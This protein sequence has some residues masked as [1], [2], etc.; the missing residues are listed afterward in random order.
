MLI[1]QRG[2]GG[3]GGGGGGLGGGGGWGGGGGG[4][5]RGGQSLEIHVGK[6]VEEKREKKQAP[7][8]GCDQAE[9]QVTLVSKTGVWRFDSTGKEIERSNANV[10]VMVS[11]RFTGDF[12]TVLRMGGANGG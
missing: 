10:E 11:E 6:K 2:G 3:G 4:R 1:G 12:W 9:Q 8:K 7:Q 5:P